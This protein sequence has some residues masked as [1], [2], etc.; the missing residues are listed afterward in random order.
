MAT[1]TPRN[2]GIDGLASL[3]F[4]T[5]AGGGDVIPAGSIRAGGHELE[6]VLLLVRNA[7]AA[8]RTVTVGDQPPVVC[9][10]TTGVSVIPVTSQGRNETGI[11][12]TYSAVADLDVAVVRLGRD[13]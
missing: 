12:V 4:E 9:P 8:T 11:P 7:N 3:T 6:T 10:A 1:L 13:Y 2:V 5:P